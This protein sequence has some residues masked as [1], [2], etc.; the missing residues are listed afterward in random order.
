MGSFDVPKRVFGTEI[1]KLGGSIQKTVISS[2]DYLIL[3][4]AGS[5][6]N[7]TPNAGTKI[8]AAVNIREGYGRLKFVNERTID[9]LLD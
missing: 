1:Q 4:A 6:H 8:K 2:T 9:K 3:A 5:E 7:V